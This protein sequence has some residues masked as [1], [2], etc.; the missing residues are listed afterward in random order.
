MFVWLVHVLKFDMHTSICANVSFAKKIKKAA[1][2]LF[3]KR[4]KFRVKLAK[5]SFIIEVVCIGVKV[6]FANIDGLKKIAPNPLTITLI[7]SQEKL[8]YCQGSY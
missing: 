5:L 8:E 3:S 7:E 1:K 2:Q 6:M 4:S